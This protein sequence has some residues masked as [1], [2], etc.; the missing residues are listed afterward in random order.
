[1]RLPIQT[2]SVVTHTRGI[3][4]RYY[5][6]PFWNGDYSTSEGDG[7]VVVCAGPGV[8]WQTCVSKPCCSRSLPRFM[9]SEQV[10]LLDVLHEYIT[11]S[12]SASIFA[13]RFR[14]LSIIYFSHGKCFCF[15][16][17]YR[18]ILNIMSRPFWLSLL[19]LRHVSTTI[20]G[21]NLACGGSVVCNTVCFNVDGVLQSRDLSSESTFGGVVVLKIWFGGGWMLMYYTDLCRRGLFRCYVVFIAMARVDSKPEGSAH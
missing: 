11:Y 15:Y 7:Q 4:V 16:A 18:V 17:L 5:R 14:S 20:S 21:C 8:C 1:M 13:I 2:P 9:Y 19:G 10:S 6:H 3:I 12:L